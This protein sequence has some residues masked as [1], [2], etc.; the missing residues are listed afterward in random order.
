MV[1]DIPAGDGKLLAFFTV[2]ST[3]V[4]IYVHYTVLLSISAYKYSVQCILKDNE[5]RDSTYI[6][7]VSEKRKFIEEQLQGPIS[8]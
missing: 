1:S 5:E 7:S 3:S 8:E 6:K 2:Y 4:D